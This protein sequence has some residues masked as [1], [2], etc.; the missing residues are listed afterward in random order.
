[1]PKKFF[2]NEDAKYL[3]EIE[4]TQKD[5][6]HLDIK[7][8]DVTGVELSNATQTAATMIFAH[9]LKTLI[10]SI[11]DDEKAFYADKITEELHAMLRD[12]YQ[13]S[14]RRILDDL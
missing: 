14:K 11:P 8:N 12:R 6:K 1:M 5:I 13:M 2:E 10:E 7:F 4:M 3:I 9:T